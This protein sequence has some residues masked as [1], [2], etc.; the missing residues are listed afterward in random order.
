MYSHRRLREPE[1][2]KILAF[3]AMI[4]LISAGSVWAGENALVIQ[5]I[6]PSRGYT[7]LELGNKLGFI[8]SGINDFEI[9]SAEDMANLQGEES[10]RMENESDYLLPPS[11]ACKYKSQYLIWV[12]VLRADSYINSSTVLPFVFKSHKRK[13]KLETE[14]RIIDSRKG[15]ILKKK[16]FEETCNGSRSLSYLE[17]DATNEPALYAD[18][19]REMRIFSELEDITARKISEEVIKATVKK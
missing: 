4:I 5:V 12:K 10:W 16:K 1:M 2:K 8:L 18:Y 15:E 13:Y 3:M 19:P 17:L 14:L 11:I 7:D 9:I 6:Q